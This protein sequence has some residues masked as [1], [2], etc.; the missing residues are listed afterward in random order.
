MSPY[1]WHLFHERYYLPMITKM[2]ED[3]RAKGLL[4]KYPL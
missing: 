2:I 4:P 3:M 1:Y